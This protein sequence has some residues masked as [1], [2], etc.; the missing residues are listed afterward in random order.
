[1][2]HRIVDIN[3]RKLVGMQM[4]MSLSNNKT[5][6]LWHSFML[7]KGTILN[8]IGFQL[9]SLQ[10]Y[11][12]MYFENFDPAIEFQK[13][14]AIEVT[15]FGTIPLGM[16]PFI[17][18]G[19]NYA[20]FVHQGPASLGPKTFQYIYGTWIPN[21]EYLLDDRPHFEILGEKYKNDA[22]GS[23]EEVWIPIKRKE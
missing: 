23:E 5:Y 13:W 15:D 19:G 1:M 11:G 6:D 16:E 17:L 21:S 14:A 18:P 10:V 4:R 9:Y 22:P 8:N 12:H 2:E 3:D 7:G 20:V